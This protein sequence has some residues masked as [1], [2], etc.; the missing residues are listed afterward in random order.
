MKERALV[1]SAVN[2][3]KERC[4]C[5]SLS[6]QLS[7][8]TTGSFY[9]IYFLTILDLQH[10]M[11]SSSISDEQSHRYKARPSQAVRESRPSLG[12]EELWNLTSGMTA[13]LSG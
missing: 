13:W 8:S 6:T 2:T 11:Q 10:L 5:L 12:I 4:R 3:R 1:H 9:N 7:I